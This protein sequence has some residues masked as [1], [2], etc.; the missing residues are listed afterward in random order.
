MSLL[1]VNQLSVSFKIGGRDVRVVNSLSFDINKGEIFGVVGE[2]GSGK[3]MTALSIMGILPENAKSDGQIFFNGEN[4]ELLSPQRRRA[5]RG[6]SVS[7][8]FQEPMTSLN[9]VLTVGY[10]IAEVLVTHKCL[11]WREA[12]NRAVELLN[13]VKIPSAQRRAKDYPHQMSGGMRQRVMIAMAIACQPEL[14]IADEPTT[15][16][17]VT[18]AAQIL[19]LIHSIKENKNM[20]VMFITHDLGI[21]SEHTDR[22]AIMYAGTIVE[23]AKTE[24][25]FNRPL[26]PYTIGLL[27]SIP[28]NKG[29]PLESILGTVPRADWLPCGCR[30]SDRCRFVLPKCLSDEPE[31][32]DTGDGRLLRCIRN[33]RLSS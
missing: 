10:Q 27:N 25:L 22:V 11:S 14:L 1:S 9:P 4:L 6:N 24:E 33:E 3:S 13:E 2:S 29:Q 32:R 7:M 16:L 12:N 8:I 5:L 20:S 26:H 31:L 21:V 18:I 17:D 28:G 23:S 19:N 15:A 30:F